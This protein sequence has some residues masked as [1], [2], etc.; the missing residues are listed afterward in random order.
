MSGIQD[1]QRRRKSRSQIKW[2]QKKKKNQVIKYITEEVWLVM[3]AMNDIEQGD[4]V[5]MCKG[6]ELF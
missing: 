4:V 2:R 6:K 1:L 5:E 3:D